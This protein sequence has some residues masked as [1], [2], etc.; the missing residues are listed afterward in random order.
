MSYISLSDLAG[1]RGGRRGGGG[2]WRRG[3][4]PP[5]PYPVPY[6]YP[7][8]PYA[9]ADTPIYPT[10]LVIMDPVDPQDEKEIEAAKEAAEKAKI[11]AIAEAVTK[12]LEKKKADDRKWF[13]LGQHANYIDVMG[14]GA[15]DSEIDV[16][17]RDDE[18]VDE[19]ISARDAL[20]WRQ[21]QGLVGLS[22]AT[23]PAKP[24]PAAAE[25][26]I[27][28]T[29]HSLWVCATVLA[30]AVAGFAVGSGCL[31]RSR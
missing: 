7:S 22:D 18:V 5:R 2:G 29:K 30:G 17:A 21:Q 12:E 15:R 8:Y 31:K 27:G 3:P 4:R 20:L 23:L 25:R 9:Y 16:E 28:V 24:A 26:G 1:P 10:P 13:G 11:Q 19:F 14:P 6:P